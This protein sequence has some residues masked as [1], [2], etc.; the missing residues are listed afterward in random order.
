MSQLRTQSFRISYRKGTHDIASDFYLPCMRHAVRYDRAV[1]FFQSTIY[2]LA[3]G[4]LKEFVASNGRM[5]V[6]CCPMLSEEDTIALREGY[7]AKADAVL[8]ARLQEEVT[9]LLDTPV[10]S[11]P[12][13][14]LA[15][16]VAIETLDLRIAFLLRDDQE[17]HRRLFHDKVGIFEDRH[18]D[19]VV[20]KGSMNETWAGLSNDG[21][22]ESVDVFLSWE[23]QRER[24]R[25]DEEIH[26]FE[27]LWANRY[28][29][30]DV[31]PFPEAARSLLSR[32]ASPSDLE[33]LLDRI[34]DEVRSQERGAAQTPTG[35]VLRPHQK[36]ALENWAS[37][38]RRGIFEHATGSGKTFTA[39]TA[40]RDSLSK[41]EVPLILVPSDLLLTQWQRELR[42]ELGDIAPDV[43]VCGGGN[44]EWRDK[45]LLETWTRPRRSA[46][47]RVV[48]ATLQTA[49]SPAFL[50]F[51]I[52]GDHLF[53]VA[54]EA[55]RLGSKR[56]SL[57][58][59]LRSGPR[60]GLSATPRRAGDPVGTA[61]VFDYFDGVVPPPFTLQ[62]AIRT[63]LTPYFYYVHTISLS[64]PEQEQWEELTQR[65]SRLVAINAD[66][67]SGLNGADQ[68]LKSLLIQRARIVKAASGK[69][70]LA[71]DVLR[72]RYKPGERWIVYCDSQQQMREV[73]TLGRGLGLPTSEYH[74]AMDGD[75]AQTLRVFE[76]HGGV[77]VA[78]RCLDE[79]VDIPAVS[80]A[81]ILA[82]SR[83]PREFIQRRGRVLRKAPGKPVAYIHD[84]IV[85]PSRLRQDG[86]GDRIVESEIAR[87]MEFSRCAENP[88]AISDLRGIALEYSLDISAL[89]VE[90][91]E[92]D[93]DE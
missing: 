75:K 74:A 13:R 52:Q 45:R 55:H 78:I 17:C 24:Q 84:T 62:D 21:N 15:T 25:V 34:A 80:H 60:L 35:R 47:R 20:F 86:Q 23:N 82:S 39:L 81:L 53:V 68:R 9:H 77:I 22:L 46:R 19:A 89:A 76:A 72:A 33:S 83:N 36:S 4:A 61:A 43:L 38:G 63:S 14:V 2:A 3:W 7:D 1:G 93:E 71:I 12:A 57:L 18:G 40:I 56:N 87:A 10:L 41:D 30:T 65:I 42:E 26:N 29:S 66:H 27:A 31:R 49:A 16:L 79:G 69:I 85:V 64:A 48:L 58:L 50:Q 5:R 67:E 37:R 11:E 28:P 70:P 6:I 44:T 8:A 51:L 91:M 92:N 54:D 59:K 88:A 32:A 90:G 73:V